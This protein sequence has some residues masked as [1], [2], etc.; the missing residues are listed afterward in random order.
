M[1]T[2]MR[3]EDGGGKDVCQTVTSEQSIKDWIEDGTRDW[4]SVTGKTIECCRKMTVVSQIVSEG[5]VG[6]MVEE[7]VKY[8]E[9]HVGISNV[10]DSCGQRCERSDEADGNQE[11]DHLFTSYPKQGLFL[12]TLHSS[13]FSQLLSTLIIHFQD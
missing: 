9:R 1:F 10:I 8:D 4:R 5:F 13:F 6:V 12:T 11:I 7:V 2:M 3:I